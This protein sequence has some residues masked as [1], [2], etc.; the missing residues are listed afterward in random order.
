MSATWGMI[1]FVLCHGKVLIEY[2]KNAVI[3]KLE[4]EAFSKH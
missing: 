2:R 1:D 4:E 3:K